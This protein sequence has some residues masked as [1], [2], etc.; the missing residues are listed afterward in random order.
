MRKNFSMASNSLDI[1]K[2]Q[3]SILKKQSYTN[4]F[5]T[6][7]SAIDP[8]SQATVQK[9]SVQP[10]TQVRNFS[11]E[12]REERDWE[13]KRKYR[14]DMDPEAVLN[15]QLA[16]DK[17]ITFLKKKNNTANKE[18]WAIYDH[19]TDDLFEECLVAG[20]STIDDSLNQYLE[21]VIVDEFQMGV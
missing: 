11:P 9:S 16:R 12:K 3:G 6:N 8:F 13:P 10:I 21:K 14:I 1:S 5:A 15:I 20:L 18:V 4:P 2:S 19:L 7:S 17:W